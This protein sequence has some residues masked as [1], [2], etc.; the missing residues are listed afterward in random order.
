MRVDGRAKLCVNRCSSDV[1]RKSRQDVHRASRQ[2]RQPSA[3]HC[4]HLTDVRLV[5]KSLGHPLEKRTRKLRLVD[6]RHQPTTHPMPRQRQRKRR[7]PP[8]QPPANRPHRHTGACRS[9]ARPA[10]QGLEACKEHDDLEVDPPGKE[11]HRRRQRASTT[12]HSTAAEPVTSAVLLARRCHEPASRLALEVAGVQRGAASRTAQS[13]GR[14]GKR[15]INDDERSKDCTVWTGLVPHS[16]PPLSSQTRR[17]A[18]SG[19]FT[20]S[21]RGFLYRPP[22]K[23]DQKSAVA[24]PASCGCSLRRPSGKARFMSYA[25]RP[26]GRRPRQ[27]GTPNTTIRPSPRSSL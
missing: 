15:L 5:A 20:S 24:P 14:I 4:D 11:S 1:P 23:L 2:R 10:E 17:W 26:S 3:C 18:P 25:K 8:R 6:R 9:V 12:T 13:P 7:R 22:K 27:L 19:A 21:S 16:P